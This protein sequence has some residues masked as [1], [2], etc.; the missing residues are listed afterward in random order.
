[1]IDEK[2]LQNLGFKKNVVHET[3][4]PKFYY[5]TLDLQSLCLISNDDENAQKNGWVVAF[6]S[7]HEFTVKTQ[8]DLQALIGILKRAA[9]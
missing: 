9:P 2:V 3:N 7:H 5:Y 1:M 8:E 6:F 4:E